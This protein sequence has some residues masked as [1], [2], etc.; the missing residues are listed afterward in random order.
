MVMTVYDSDTEQRLLR[1]FKLLNRFMIIMWRLGLGVWLKS[2]DTW[3]QIMVIGHRGRKTGIMRRTPVNY[4]IVDDDLYCTAGFG[5]DSDWYRNVLANP[6]VEIWHPE[7]WWKGVVE[8]VS[9][10]SDR[11]P[12]MREVLIGSGFAARIAGMNPRAMTDERLDLMSK[13]Y[14]LLR[15][16]RTEAMTGSRGPG[17]LAWIWPLSTLALLWVIMRRNRRR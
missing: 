11:I 1:A 8:D 7:G 6:E 3:G 16:R 15:I 4:A 12:L 2:K 14:R 9:E 17:D 10:S 13:S 5:K